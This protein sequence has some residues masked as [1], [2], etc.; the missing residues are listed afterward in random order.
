[1]REVFVWP[2]VHNIL[3]Q[4]LD[5]ECYDNLC[6]RLVTYLE[7]RY[8]RLRNDRHP[9]DDTLFV[10]TLYQADGDKRHT[11][12]FHIDDTTADTCLIVLN[13]VHTVE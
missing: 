4:N 10:C 8:A 5:K 12:E 13:V 9:A 2:T 1:V 11:F 6:A 7:K 3:W